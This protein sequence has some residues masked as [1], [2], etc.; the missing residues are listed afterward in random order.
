MMSEDGAKHCKLKIDEANLFVQ[1]MTV[2]DNVVG[3]IEKTLLKTSAMNRYNEVISKAFLATAGQQ[4]WKQEDIFTKE[5]IR[6]LIV[7]MSASSAFIGTNIQNPFSYQKSHLNGKTVYR[8]G[9]VTAGTPMSTRDD[10]RL[11]LYSLGALA[12]IES[13][14]GISLADFPHHFIKVFDVT[15]TQE[16]TDDFI[17]P[18]LTNSSLSVQ[19]K[20]S[21]ALPNNIEILFLGEKCS[22][23]YID[24]ARN[25]S[26]NVLPMS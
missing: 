10:K 24:S 21:A 14:H 17:H 23:V 12:F 1:K 11:Y 4:S 20:F 18:K 2:S 15:S 22:T 6:R 7:A 3:A 16:A 26:K 5:P 19:R 8:N 25:V 13:G 9:F